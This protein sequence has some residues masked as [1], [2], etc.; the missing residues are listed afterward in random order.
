M[1]FMACAVAA[2]SAAAAVV[3]VALAFALYAALAPAWGP[4]L[5]GAGVAG[6]AALLI[7]IGGLVALSVAK[8]PRKPL[9]AKPDLPTRLIDL[10][11]DKP[12]VAAAALVAAGLVAVRSPQVTATVISSFLASRAAAKTKK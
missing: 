12:M 5:A 9:D 4:A 8:G 2:L 7:L 3:V 11:R 1:I 10:A 6:A